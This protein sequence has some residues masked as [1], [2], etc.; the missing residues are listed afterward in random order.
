LDY[1]HIQEHVN[2]T[3]LNQIGQIKLK[4]QS[5]NTNELL[6]K[7]QLSSQDNQSFADRKQLLK[8]YILQKY[9]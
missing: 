7:L 1:D 5:I 4:K 6:E 2:E 9:Q 8:D 3:L